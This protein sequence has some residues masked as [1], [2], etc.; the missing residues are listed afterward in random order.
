MSATEANM[1]RFEKTS[2]RDFIALQRNCLD[3]SAQSLEAFENGGTSG[4]RAKEADSAFLPWKS[5][6][7]RCPPAPHPPS[8]VFWVLS[9][10]TSCCFFKKKEGSIRVPNRLRCQ[11]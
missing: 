9:Q 11:T 6:N 4:C 5:E 1:E 7:K 8:E 10:A 3:Y 2:K